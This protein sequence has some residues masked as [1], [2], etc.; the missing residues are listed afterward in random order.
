MK[1]FLIESRAHYNSI[2]K[3]NLFLATN[4]SLF[5]LINK[6]N[7]RYLHEKNS[8]NGKHKYISGLHNIF[9]NWYRDKKGVDVFFSNG[10]SIAPVITKSLINLFLNDIRNFDTIEY[11]LNKYKYIYLPRNASHSLLR[12]KKLFNKRLIFYGDSNN[13]FSKN[14]LIQSTPDR[15][16]YNFSDHRKSYFFQFL[17]RNLIKKKKILFFQDW[18]LNSN[19][20]KKLTNSNF[21]NDSNFLIGAYY[22]N[23]FK[24]HIKQNFYFRK[25]L[26]N[27]SKLNIYLKKFSPRNW[28][29]YK[30]IFINNFIYI[31]NKNK[32]KINQF[33]NLNLEMINFYKPKYITQFGDN[34]WRNIIISQICQKNKIT[35]FLL[36]DGYLFMKEKILF[37][38]DYL[39]KKFI[40]DIFFAY[41]NA[42][43]KLILR[44]GIKKNVIMIKPFYIDKR[45]FNCSHNNF[46]II[47][48]LPYLY[49]PE[50]TP[51]KQIKIEVE[52]LRL[53]QSLDI[54]NLSFKIKPGSN[55]AKSL[56]T[57]SEDIY[58]KIFYNTYNED[59]KIKVNFEY[60]ILSKILYKY[61][62]A[63][64]P[65]STALIEL[66]N[67]KVKYY[68][69]EPLENGLSDHMINSIELF[70]K[71]KFISR[72]IFELKKNLINNN[73]LKLANKNF[74]SG[75]NFSDFINQL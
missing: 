6:K 5:K 58:K 59:L 55:Y 41:G 71:N 64:G 20:K 34:G 14:N 19:V 68:V 52:I 60:N 25:N 3:N 40:F 35:N 51:D 11:W 12:I 53:L 62:T 73:Y 1:L 27:K 61:K 42:H 21:F 26:F 17:N 16:D 7:V 74:N 22:N 8:Y 75:L 43:K 13:S 10:I 23:S 28:K 67:A 33:Y 9:L 44:N 57:R 38:K 72:N 70:N 37:L 32:I 18:I 46:L 30:K 50:I 47:T 29:I 45:G 48:Y 15:D 69:Y 36:L 2:N 39:N 63:I 49:N 31:F 54:K 4:Y 24:N 56:Q 65:I 66:C